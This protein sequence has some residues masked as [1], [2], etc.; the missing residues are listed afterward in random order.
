LTGNQSTERSFDAADVSRAS[1]SNPQEL[2]EEDFLTDVLEGLA[3]QPKQ[4]PCKYFYDQRGSQLFDRICELDEY[5]LTRTELAIMDEFIDEMAWQLGRQVMLVEFGSG[6]SI[7]TRKL[8][9]ALDDPVAYVPIDISE[10]HLMRTARELQESYPQTEILP[11]VADFTSDLKLPRSGRTPSHAVVYFP[12][13]TIGNFT[14]EQ[15]ETLLSRFS[16]FLGPDGGL[17]I[18]IDLQKDPRVIRAAYNDEAGVTAEFNLN[19]LHRIN[20]ELGGD[21]D[22]RSFRHRAEYNQERGRVE[23]DLVSQCPQTVHI[24]GRVFRFA[25]GEA[26]HTEYSHKYTIDS[27]ARLAARAGF[28]LHRS[29]TDSRQYVAVLHLVHEGP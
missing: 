7:K 29:W 1:T 17:L 22:V 21:F 10:E 16:R 5:Y 13:S 9:D 3:K 26:I 15:A 4:L 19:L 8:L 20:R 25:A 12:G 14:P 23:I 11:V 28:T 2:L 24:D 6:S 18:G 27:F